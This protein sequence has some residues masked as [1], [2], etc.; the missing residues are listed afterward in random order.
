M[1]CDRGGVVLVL[2]GKS[3]VGRVLHWW[4]RVVSELRGGYGVDRAQ[5]DESG[6]GITWYGRPES[7]S[8]NGGGAR[9]TSYDGYTD[10]YIGTRN[11][12]A[13]MPEIA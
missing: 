10:A 5:R 4:C 6:M 7:G 3:R 8:C 13:Y 12:V 9:I 11:K 2:R 1:R